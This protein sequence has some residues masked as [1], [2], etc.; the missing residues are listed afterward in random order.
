MAGAGAAPKAK[1]GVVLKT[2]A[3]AGAPKE[4]A[5]AGALEP[6]AAVDPNGVRAGAL[7]DGLA[8]SVCAAFG[9]PNMG[10]GA[11]DGI[12]PKAN[13]AELNADDGAVGAL[14]VAGALEPKLKTDDFAV[15][16]CVVVVAAPAAPKPENGVAAAVVVAGVAPEKPA[17]PLGLAASFPN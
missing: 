9:P 2:G 15:S 1:L 8:T 7:E 10:A 16:D 12:A 17:K 11:A 4:N 6:N 5:G 13:G 14:D 3:A